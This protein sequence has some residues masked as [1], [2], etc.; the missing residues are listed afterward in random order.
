MARW[1]LS[2]RVQAIGGPAKSVSVLD[3]AGDQVSQ[4]SL[5]ELQAEIE[6][7]DVFFAT[8]GFEV[9]QPTGV[10][11]L[12]AWL[13]NLQIGNAV[14]IGIL[15]PGDAALKLF[16]DYIVEGREAI[17]S[18]NFLADFL[19]NN[20]AGAVSVS[21]ASHSL[22]ARVVL[23]TVS[24]LA[25]GIN[26]RR[27]LLMA[28][29]IDNTCLV[30]EYASAASKVQELSLLASLGD[31]VLSFAFPL[32]NP[33]MGILDRGHP[34]YRAAIGHRGPAQPFPASP[35]LQASW[36]IPPEWGYGHHDY[37]QDGGLPHDQQFPLPVEIP[38]SGV[39]RPPVGAP[40]GLGGD[41]WKPAWS[42]GF[43]STRFK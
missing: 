39:P 19:N 32:G 29:A 42:A 7:R 4:G 38:P 25:S 23:Q 16:V 20:F 18:G 3:A 14:K 22:G 31:D 17:Q 33:I 36:Q 43:A 41:S 11:E 13:D 27:V 2:T 37:L 34:Y 40:A 21:F 12:G 28:G 1:F 6:G 24:G 9:D 10:K 26:V 8:H 5:S 35:P 30:N 15:W